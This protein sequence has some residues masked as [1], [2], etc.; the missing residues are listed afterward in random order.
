MKSINPE[1]ISTKEL[2]GLLLTAVAPRPI[3]FISTISEDGVPNLAPFSFFNV[4]SANPPIM[5][6]SP[7]RR[8]RDNTIKDTLVNC[9]NTKEAVVNIVDYDMVQQMSLASSEYDSG[10]DEFKKAGFTAL[11]SISVK[12]PRVGESPVQF[13]CKIDQIM[14][15][16]DQGGAGNLIFAKVVQIHVQER[17][18]NENGGLDPNKLDLV[19]RMGGALYSRALEGAFEI[20]KPLSHLGIGFDAMP[21]EIRESKALTS[22]EK[23]LL[24]GVEYLP[25]SVDVDKFMKDN[26]KCIATESDKKYKFASALLAENKIMHAWCVLLQ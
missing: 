2:H 21:K 5:I 16:G 19:A 4:F 7:A 17:F 14:P 20:P 23:A 24:A 26:P 9:Q 3:G 22:N 10:T 1:N 8:V 18:L 25:E 6:F 13:E 12:A 11:D 15:L